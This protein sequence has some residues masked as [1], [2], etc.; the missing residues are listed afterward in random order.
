MTDCLHECIR[1]HVFFIPD[2]SPDSNE[3]PLSCFFSKT[4]IAM[5]EIIEK[6]AQTRDKVDLAIVHKRVWHDRVI[7]N[8]ST[9]GSFRNQTILQFFPMVFQFMKNFYGFQDHSYFGY[10]S[11]E[12]G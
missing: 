8:F 6:D 12:L 11:H 4:K 9:C 1:S 3:N 7:W 10:Q 2:S 5:K